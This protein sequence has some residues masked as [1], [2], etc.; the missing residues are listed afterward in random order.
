MGTVVT[1]TSFCAPL[2]HGALEDG[3]NEV[4]YAH[5]QAREVPFAL[6]CPI[7]R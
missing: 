4:L 1:G 5:G 3:S 2:A 7:R 6:K